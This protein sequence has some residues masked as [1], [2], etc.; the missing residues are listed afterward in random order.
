MVPVA[1]QM[2]SPSISKKIRGRSIGGNPHRS[3]WYASGSSRSSS[4]TCRMSSTSA[5]LGTSSGRRGRKPTKG[6]MNDRLM[7][8]AR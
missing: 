5:G 7:T 2:V 8:V 6:T 1:P 4:G 3:S